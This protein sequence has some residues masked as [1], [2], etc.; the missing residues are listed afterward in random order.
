MKN[1]LVSVAV[2]TNLCTNWNLETAFRYINAAGFKGA[3]ILCDWPHAYAARLTPQRVKD[4]KAALAETRL[5]A[6]SVNGF[7]AT[8]FAREN[9]LEYITKALTPN[10]RQYF[11]PIFS[12]AKEVRR[13][14]KVAYTK[15]VVDFADAIGAR[16][17]SIGSGY[18][19]DGVDREQAWVW[20]REAIKECVGYA[21][22]KGVNINIE[23][24]PY[25]L[26]GSDQD[27]ARLLKEI[28]SP[29]FG[30]NFDIG[31]SFV[32]GEN[33]MDQIRRFRDRIH[34]TDIEDIG[35]DAEGNRVHRHLVPGH[36]VMPLEE[37]MRTFREIG[38][39]GKHTLE[40]YS[41]A[42]RPLWAMEESMT[43]FKSLK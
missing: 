6:A 19:P 4:I 29:N 20:M 37:I 41:Q 22:R 5:F 31:H 10:G 26:V 38:Y 7:T 25:L 1:L 8:G 39:G 9:Q 40:L 11:G 30:L 32:C 15:R 36:G 21:A 14:W 34:G 2:G 12:D 18:P 28:P 23:Y 24:E 35:L 17:V 27:A 3:T 16:N 33:V 42:A 13:H 43:Y